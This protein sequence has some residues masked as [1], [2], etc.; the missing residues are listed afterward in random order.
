[1]ATRRRA[2]G[3][4]R[5]AGKS[6]WQASYKVNGQRFVAPSTFPSK[7]DASAWLANVQ[8]DINRGIWTDPTGGVTRPLLATSRAGS[9][10]NRRPATT[11]PRTLELV[12]GLL[13][14]IILPALGDRE[15]AEIKAPL[16]RSWHAQ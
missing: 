1:M 6:S 13:D 7:A 10:A 11:V 5:P 12:T 3:N 14:R 2:F 15:L 9:T 16:V 4:I 8:A